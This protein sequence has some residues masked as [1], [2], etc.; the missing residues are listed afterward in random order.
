MVELMITVGIVGVLSAT[1]IPSFTGAIRRSKTAEVPSNLDSM[2]KLAASYYSSERAGR[3]NDVAVSG[4][5]VV[6]DAGPEPVQPLPSKQ[7]FNPDANFRALNFTLADQTY[8]SYGLVSRT[9]FSNCSNA[10][11]S[12]DLYTFMAHGDLDGDS[13]EST[14][15]L[16]AGSDASNVLYHGRAMFID[17]EIE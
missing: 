2:F 8:Y 5:C 9:S 15:E 4:Y 11:K 16:A 12:L 14:F 7:A 17:K 10:P 13:V 3:G 6:G 1:A